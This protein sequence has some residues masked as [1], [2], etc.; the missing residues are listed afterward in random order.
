[1]CWKAGSGD[2]ALAAGSSVWNG[3]IDL[4]NGSIVVTAGQHSFNGLPSIVNGHLT[5]ASNAIVALTKPGQVFNIELQQSQPNTLT[6]FGSLNQPVNGQPQLFLG[7]ITVGTLVGGSSN[8]GG[9][10]AINGSIDF[11]AAGTPNNIDLTRGS[12]SQLAVVNAVNIPKT[13]FFGT[14][15]FGLAG[16]ITLNHGTLFDQAVTIG[17]A[18]SAVNLVTNGP[19]RTTFNSTVTVVSGSL[20]LTNTGFTLPYTHAVGALTLNG[21][22]D[23]SN[24]GSG[25]A[26]T[27]S[28]S[29]S[30]TP[31]FA[32]TGTQRTAGVFGVRDTFF[33]DLSI[34]PPVTQTTALALTFSGNNALQGNLNV[35]GRAL[36][37]GVALGRADVTLANAQSLTGALVVTG[38][39]VTVASANALG[40]GGAGAGVT[41]QGEKAVLNFQRGVATAASE[42]IIIN[43]AATAYLSGVAITNYGSTYPNSAQTVTVT[44]GGATINAGGSG[45]LATANVGNSNSLLSITLTNV[46]EGFNAVPTVTL[47]NNGG[48]QF[49]PVFGGA[50]I[51]GQD[52]HTILNGALILNNV[53]GGKVALGVPMLSVGAD[54]SLQ[55]TGDL[56]GTTGVTLPNTSLYSTGQLNGRLLTTAILGGGSLNSAGGLLILSGQVKDVSTGTATVGAANSASD[57]L[58]VEFAGSNDLNIHLEKPWYSNGLLQM[59]QGVLRYTNPAANAAFWQ[60][61]VGNAPTPS[62]ALSVPNTAFGHASVGYNSITSAGIQTAAVFLTQPGQSFNAP[63]WTAYLGNANKIANDGTST[64]FIVIGGENTSGTVTYG[65][66]G[67][68]IVLDADN[69]PGGTANLRD[70]RLVAS[71]GGTVDLQHAFVKAAGSNGQ[72]SIDKVGDG[73]VW[74]SGSGTSPTGTAS[75][76]DKVFV[77]GGVL[78]LRN[79]GQFTA[80]RLATIG[81][82]QMYLNGGTLRLFTGTATGSV[83]ATG[84]INQTVTGPS[85][86][87]NGLSSVQVLP[88]NNAST[89]TI[90]SNSSPLTRS[91]GGAVRFAIAPGTGGTGTIIFNS[92]TS[93][94]KGST[95]PTWWSSYGTE[96]DPAGA[97]AATNFAYIDLPGS[98]GQVNPFTIDATTGLSTRN[99]DLSAIAANTGNIEEAGSGFTGQLTYTSVN[100]VRFNG[101]ASGGTGNLGLGGLHVVLGNGTTPGAILLASNATGGNRVISNGF[102]TSLAANDLVLQNW[103]SDGVTQDGGGIVRPKLTVSAIIENNSTNDNPLTIAGDGTT[104]LTGANTFRGNVFINGGTVE[105]ASPTAFGNAPTLVT[106]IKTILLEGGTLHT[107]DDFLWDN[108]NI[109]VYGDR[110]TIQVD[111]GKTFLLL[112][113]GSTGGIN[114]EAPE[115]INGFGI[116]YGATAS[117]ASSGSANIFNGDLVISGGASG[118]TAGGTFLQARDNAANT[119]AGQLFVSGNGRLVFE[120]NTAGFM[121]NNLSWM[122][123]TTV[124]SG[125][126]LELHPTTAVATPMSIGEYLHLNGAGQPGAGGALVMKRPTQIANAA[127]ALTDRNLNWTGPITLDGGTTIFVDDSP[128][129]VAAGTV[130]QLT[131]A[132]NLFDGGLGTLT[133]NGD[134]ILDFNGGRLQ[135]LSSIVVAKGEVRFE[136]GLLGTI[137]SE[138]NKT[139]NGLL[140]TGATYAPA[141]SFNNYTTGTNT[142]TV[143]TGASATFASGARLSFVDARG[144]HGADLTLNNGFLFVQSADAPLQAISFA[145]D[146][147]LT[148]GSA[149][150]AIEAVYTNRINPVVMF[151]AFNGTGGFTKFGNNELD[152]VNPNSAFSGEILVARGA[153]NLTTPG[154]ALMDGGRFQNVGSIRLTNDGSFFIDNRNSLNASAADDNSTD[155]INDSAA[156]HLGGASQLRFL[157]NLTTASSESV[158][159][160]NVHPGSSAVNLAPSA[161]GQNVGMSFDNYT[162]DVGG[163]VNFRVLKAGTDFGSGLGPSGAPLTSGSATIDIRNAIDPSMFKGGGRFNRFGSGVDVES[164][165]IVVGAFG[166][167]AARDLATL[168]TNTSNTL[169]LS[170]NDTLF[171]GRGLMT[172]AS[173]QVSPGVFTKFLR[174]LKTSEYL[175]AGPARVNLQTPRGLRVTDT[176]DFDSLYEK[177]A[178]DPL[179]P[180]SFPEIANGQN[181]NVR[182]IGGFGPSTSASSETIFATEGVYFFDQRD[183]SRL[184]DSLY[185]VLANISFNSLTFAQQTTELVDKGGNRLLLEIS[186]DKT[187][188]IG[189]GMILHA[190]LGIIGAAAPNAAFNSIQSAL[191]RGG[192]L[193][194]GNVEGIIQNVAAGLNETTGVF[195]SNRLAASSPVANNNIS[196]S[197]LTISSRITG[198]GGITKSGPATVNLSG[199]NSYSGNTNV[200]EGILRLENNLALGNSHLVNISGTGELR[201]Q[202][203]ITVGDPAN[204]HALQVKFGSMTQPAVFRAEAGNNVFN[205]DVVVNTLNEAGDRVSTAATAFDLSLV[206]GTSASFTIGGDIYGVDT[207]SGG[208]NPLNDVQRGRQARIVNFNNAAAS[209]GVIQIRGVFK[210]LPSG[211]VPG[212]VTS[213]N[214]DQVLR[215]AFTGVTNS[216]FFIHSTWDAAGSILLRQGALRLASGATD[217]FSVA[218]SN[219]IN[220]SN[221]QAHPII[222]DV[223][224]VGDVLLSLTT[225]GQIFNAPTLQIMSNASG[226]NVTLGGENTSGTVKFFAPSL[227]AAASTQFND[228]SLR[229]S[230]WDRNV[231]LYAAAGGM[232][233]FAGRIT[234]ATNNGSIEKVGLG[235]VILSGLDGTTANYVNGT[236]NNNDFDR[237]IYVGSGKL[238]L[239]ANVNGNTAV[240][241]IFGTT[242]TPLV[243]GGGQLEIRGDATV[244][245]LETWNGAP[246]FRGGAS[247][248]ALANSSGGITLTIGSGQTTTRT[249]G[250]T[251]NFVSPGSSGVISYLSAAGAVNISSG[252]LGPWATFG[253]TPGTA[254]EFAATASG[255]ATRTLIALPAVTYATR[256]DPAA[257]SVGE[258]LA[259]GAGGFQSAPAN[260]LT[261]SV[262]LI[263]FAEPGT[264]SALRIQDAGITLGTSGL[265]EGAILVPTGTTALKS[266]IGGPMQ[267]NGNKELYLF[268]YG[269]GGLNVTAPIVGAGPLVISGPGTTTLGRNMQ[270]GAVYLNGG[271][272]SIDKLNYEPLTFSTSVTGSTMITLPGGTNL[273]DIRTGSTVTGSTGASL[274]TV[275]TVNSATNQITI[276]TA[277]PAGTTSLTVT[278]TSAVFSSVTLSA[279]TSTNTGTY[280]GTPAGLAI[281]TSVTGTGVPAG[282]T[283]TAVNGTTITFSNTLTSAQVLTLAV[284]NGLG[285]ALATS[286]GFSLNGA[287]VQYTGSTVLTDRNFLVGDNGATIEVTQP[288]TTLQLNAIVGG[289]NIVTAT[290]NNPYAISITKTGPGT[291]VVSQATGLGNT[292]TGLIDVRQGTL[293]FSG[294]VTPLGAATN[295]LDGT[296][297]RG[298]ATLRFQPS[299]DLTTAEWITFEDNSTFSFAPSTANRTLNLDGVIQ[300]QGQSDWAFAGS[301]AGSSVIVLNPNAGYLTGAGSIHKG[302]VNN[303]SGAANGIFGGALVLTESNTE[304]SGGFSIDGG[305]LVIKSVGQPAGTG[306]AGRP[307]ILGTAGGNDLS[308]SISNGAPE[309]QL[310]FQMRD[311]VNANGGAT[312]TG[313]FDSFQVNVGIP[314]EIVV[315]RPSDAQPGQASSQVKKIGVIGTGLSLDQY[316]LNGNLRLKDDLQFYVE[317]VFSNVNAGEES[318]NFNLNGH[319]ISDATGYAP[320]FTSKLNIT[321]RPGGATLGVY[322]N[323]YAVISLNNSN[324]NFTGNLAIGNSAAD[325]DANHVLRLNHDQ[326]LG[327]TNQVTL[328]NNATLQIPGHHVTIGSLVDGTGNVSFSPTVFSGGLTTGYIVSGSPAIVENGS[329]IP[330]VLTFSQTVDAEWSFLIRDGYTVDGARTAPLGLVK[331]GPGTVRLLNPNDFSGGLTVR[332]GTVLVRS[333]S[334]SATGAG[335]VDVIGATFGGDNLSPIAGNLT[336]M[337][338]GVHQGVLFPG[339]IDNLGVHQ[340]RPMN[341]SNLIFGGSNVG[342]RMEIHTA[343]TEQSGATSLVNLVSLDVNAPVQ[344]NLHL[345]YD[346]SGAGHLFTPGD[347]VLLNGEFIRLFVSLDHHIQFGAGGHFV[348]NGQSVYDGA[349]LAGFYVDQNGTP[350][351]QEFVMRLSINSSDVRLTA[352]PEPNV[353]LTFTAGAALLAGLSRRRKAGRDLSLPCAA[354]GSPH[355]G[356]FTEID[357][358]A[359]CPGEWSPS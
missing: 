250:A 39:Q 13:R 49:A 67:G 6:I 197:D 358:S 25:S 153:G 211:A 132:G 225:G 162:R 129:I 8:P 322:H 354:L 329:E 87:R 89:M 332:E 178:E 232:V 102:L 192:T 318:V 58:N 108:R 234:D 19:G 70:L 97:N 336:I 26:L 60:T 20:T 5:N 14:V 125:S 311:Q 27:I 79:F 188:T 181:K 104:V 323:L 100:T 348:Y 167:V 219:A 42:D 231:R 88:G 65:T 106:D 193:N 298:G 252:L 319:I 282:T 244:R 340:G 47:T 56:Y 279:A 305:R 44:G 292:Q 52:Q 195:T 328:L 164:T 77:S 179:N 10:L 218:A 4:T 163:V 81:T 165:S 93:T 116:T 187:L 258:Y 283:I 173:V 237:G 288:T 291:L 285:Q 274:G 196:A 214:E 212:L 133:K 172:I 157:G 74:L 303:G 307:I 357:A 99:D 137:G 183:E 280:T 113:N 200:V 154:V 136:G 123:G 43:A 18:A 221:A 233:E 38:G 220:P 314:Q 115:V 75:A 69:T 256:T 346:G 175:T 151:G 35:N 240:A 254:T 107:T 176:Y 177:G 270:T 264:A 142:I 262:K 7:Q 131:M 345:L 180:G 41:L 268:N 101:D 158:G 55:I 1:M 141:A 155:R 242:A 310:Y 92:G 31:T 85:F 73:T 134:G 306:A 222:G 261:K 245:A 147:T 22:D 96:L 185:R 111:A 30:V 9:T 325:P 338:D 257:A 289:N 184:Q 321:G 313:A 286:S 203:G 255:D 202:R 95:N 344:L 140:H 61:G 267:V 166:G 57:I 224:A 249:I 276:T 356:N 295:A 359:D 189:S 170:N 302:T 94:N 253:L 66:H 251:V 34:T 120:G 194:F 287:T 334:G 228:A 339:L 126:T 205:G 122:D 216:N 50:V 182:L 174:P 148:G 117:V 333:A 308:S 296:I 263:R 297:V 201:M 309:A 160:L 271:V 139:A 351:A 156:I 190:G 91:A 105:V 62:F 300:V 247:E 312:L 23:F 210:D 238:I 275:L 33:G 103:G 84:S 124:A 64:G 352:I 29:V 335:K 316:N 331:M 229:V 266:I 269:T 330:A 90:G 112:G 15:T 326:A 110:S 198:S 118:Q 186:P 37:P 145:G 320:T 144:T 241:N 150:N 353:P 159:V 17:Q 78:E 204:P 143:G 130:G 273:S 281:G 21:L 277:A 350:T 32:Q 243:L 53:S 248:V 128:E 230:S 226:A 59:A 290:T 272:I 215:S 119:I 24:N 293:A 171:A 54:D 284:P 278:P 68:S 80:Q 236:S 209:G 138:A 36:L 127:A 235:T 149:S 12:L 217:F 3:S 45:T 16:T 76:L 213:A 206:N 63:T 341:V 347:P 191:I 199:A 324:P 260:A 114:S 294:T 327:S 152:F 259:E 317:D 86:I 315:N 299:V 135:S 239:D 208:I 98:G 48:G 265:D 28:G 109:V 169:A 82:A 2:L 223:T 161:S 337:D 168:P 227:T 342:D 301:S 246:N 121:G 146:V 207:A 40:V 72:I 343:G 355:R 11:G 349:N 71:A 51:R 304:F 46:G 83:G